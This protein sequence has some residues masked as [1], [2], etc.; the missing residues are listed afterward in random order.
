MLSE[1]AELAA[2][3]WLL[4][5]VMVL[6]GGHESEAGELR[7]Y[8]G[9]MCMCILCGLTETQDLVPPTHPDFDSV[10]RE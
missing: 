6:R 1:S 10:S 2:A 9:S 7:H 4:R 3:S 8:R 5:A